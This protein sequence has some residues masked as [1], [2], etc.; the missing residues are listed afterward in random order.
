VTRTQKGELQT[1]HRCLSKDKP[2]HLASRGWVIA[3]AFLAFQLFSFSMLLIITTST[4]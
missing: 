4:P 3:V 2:L 1:V